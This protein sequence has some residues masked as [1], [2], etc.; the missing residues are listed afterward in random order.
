M[1]FKRFI[2]S[3]MHFVGS[4]IAKKAILLTI[5]S[6]GCAVISDSLILKAQDLEQTKS[7]LRELYSNRKYDSLLIQSQQFYQSSLQ[8]ND[9]IN[10]TWALYYQSLA[11]NRISFQ[12][13]GQTT[14][15]LIEISELTEE[16][17]L[18][19]EAHKL[20]SDYYNRIS[21][22]D[23]S[24]HHLTRAMN[25]IESSEGF[26]EDSLLRL[27]LGQ[28]RHNLA[29]QFYAGQE[30]DKAL[31]VIMSNIEY[32]EII[33]DVELKTRAY[34]VISAIYSALGTYAEETNSELNIDWYLE[35]SK[36]YALLFVDGTKK[37]NSSYLTGFGYTMIANIFNNEQQYDSSAYY[38]AKSLEYVD[39]N[40]DPVSYSSRLE[41]VANSYHQLGNFEQATDLYL[42]ALEVAEEAGSDLMVTGLANNLSYTYLKMQRLNEARNYANLSIDLGFKLK[43]WGTV[44]QGYGN[45][46]GI[47]EEA[48]NFREALSAYEMH[49][50]YRDS[51]LKEENL[52]RIEELETKYE[53][54]QKEAEIELLSRQNQLQASQIKIRNTQFA[55]GGLFFVVVL[56]MG[57]IGYKK[58]IIKKEKEIQD[59]QQ[60]LLSVQ[61]N[62]HFLFNALV[63]IQNFV[64]RKEDS[65]VTSMFVAKFAKVTRLVLNYSRKQWITLTDEVALLE[66]FLRLQ[67]IRADH[68]FE[69]KV[70]VSGDKNTD[71]IL[72]PP[73]LTQ[74]FI[75]NAVEHAI[76]PMEGKKGKINVLFEIGKEFVTVLVE[77]NGGGIKEIQKSTQNEYESLS[78]AI[79]SE[80]F[81]LLEK[82]T[83]KPFSFEIKNKEG[84]DETGLMIT[85]KVPLLELD[86]FADRQNKVA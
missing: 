58:I 9:K 27:K 6:Y 25:I 7:E 49:I 81:E 86:V 82:I 5:I 43:R 18:T 13:F 66:E 79:T 80:R 41:K 52:A 63:S 40:R 84:L 1:I 54:E 30:F 45:L 15:T 69:Y 38:F 53:T 44:S 16:Y 68:Q 59:A 55:L 50:Q 21:K 33:N 26:M 85:F 14:K 72:I 75:E 71:E 17:F 35:K 2:F 67:Q 29:T 57:Y 19:A 83:E 28:Y 20:R 65:R 24:I 62:P 47:E 32:A 12:N 64:M 48:G 77:D 70:E 23:S 22:R 3:I 11:E 56:L 78:N 37:L 4:S 10:Q 60:R 76:L 73:M 46:S 39:R 61:M 74:P 51:L 8:Q 34:Q 42:E 36:E 31:E